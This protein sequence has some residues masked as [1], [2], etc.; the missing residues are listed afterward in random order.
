MYDRWRAGEPKSRLEEEYWGNTTSHGKAFT[1]Y[2]KRWLDLETE[3]KSSQTAYVEQLEARL[4]ALGVEPV[5]GEDLDDVHRLLAAAREAALAA[6][7]I[8]NDP[9]AG[10]RTETFI[11]L[12]VVAWNSLLQAILE[13]DDV[14]CLQRDDDGKPIMQDGRPK[15]HDTGRFVE[16]ALPGD[17]MRGVRANLDFFLGLRNRI[18]HR[19]LPALDHEVVG[20]AQAMLLNFESIL[21]DE[22]G[23]ASALGD[24]LS[25]ALQL[26]RFRSSE[27]DEAIKRAQAKLPPDVMAYLQKH[28]D[29]LPDEV[30]RDPAYSMRVFFVPITANRERQADAVVNFIKPGTTTPELEKALAGMAVVQKPRRVAVASDHLLRPMEVVDRVK[31]RL[32]FRFT[33]DTHVR[34]WKHYKVRPATTAA[35]KDVTDDRY[36]LYDRLSKGYG[37]TEAWVDF[38]VE[39]LSNP[40]RYE[41]VVGYRP[42]ES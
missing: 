33:P 28:R 24:R 38:L 37:Y 8:Y 16:L 15:V 36:C 30:I 26:S 14:D 35:E 1:T 23:A 19:Y 10:F 9:S 40:D 31:A 3:K 29:D 17:L 13:R 41:Q 32:A 34:A 22:F 2:I 39:E 12:M 7:R 20:E 25:V 4:R 21:S 5:E 11:L 42:A 18:A 6:L 27:G